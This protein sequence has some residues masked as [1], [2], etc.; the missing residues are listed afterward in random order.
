MKPPISWVTKTPPPSSGHSIT[1]KGPHLDNGDNFRRT[2]PRQDKCKWARREKR[3]GKP[4]LNEICAGKSPFQ[5]MVP[6]CRQHGSDQSID[7]ALA[8]LPGSPSS[9]QERLQGRWILKRSSSYWPGHETFTQSS[10]PLLSGRFTE[11][12]PFAES[13]MKSRKSG[14]ALS[15]TT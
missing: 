12:K 11:I 9:V 15:F 10:V 1:G 2:R 8:L 3:N 5:A 14:S 6:E 7:L 13:R 4:L